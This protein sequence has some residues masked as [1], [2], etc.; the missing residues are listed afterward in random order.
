MPL[1]Q[2]HIVFTEGFSWETFSA[3]F[4]LGESLQHPSIEG[5]APLPTGVLL[6]RF[7]H[8][9]WKAQWNVP[10]ICKVLKIVSTMMQSLSV[11]I[12]VD[13]ITP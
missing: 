8:E 4:I 12:H 5:P 10:F 2:A 1:L 7:R 11:C 6:K 13:P 3:C 9:G